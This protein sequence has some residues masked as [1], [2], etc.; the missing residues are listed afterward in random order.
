MLT[1]RVLSFVLVA[2][3][4]AL[5]DHETGPELAPLLANDALRT[6][7][8][9]MTLHRCTACAPT[10]DNQELQAHFAECVATRKRGDG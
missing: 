4:A 3:P 6:L 8:R 10:V 9:F 5:P 7:E 1:W 2:K